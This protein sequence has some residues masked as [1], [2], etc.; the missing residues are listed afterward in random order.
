[1]V[2]YILPIKGLSL[3]NHCYSYKID[4]AFFEKFDHFGNDK[5]SLDLS[6]DMVKESNLMDFRFHFTGG[7]DLQCDR[8]LDFY[9]LKVD[10]EFRLIVNYGAKYE[11]I[12]DEAITIPSDESNLDLSQFV[13]EFINLMIPLRKVHPDDEEGNPT[14][15]EEMMERLENLSEK[16][17]DPR[18]E[19]LKDIKFD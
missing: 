13:Y 11:E 19:A 1:M 16:K 10:Q 4:N 17:T 18:W 15:N 6:I 14:C 12:S 7:L 3:G 9:T 5:G 2:E 8:C